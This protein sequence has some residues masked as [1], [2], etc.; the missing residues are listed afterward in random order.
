MVEGT[1]VFQAE[2]PKLKYEKFVKLS[3]HGSY[4]SLEEC[5]R[6]IVLQG[7]YMLEKALIDNNGGR[8]LE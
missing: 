8:P 1:V 4:P 6:W 3:E 7:I 2:I 5:A